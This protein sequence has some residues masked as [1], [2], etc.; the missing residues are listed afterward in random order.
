MKKINFNTKPANV[1]KEANYQVISCNPR[2]MKIYSVLFPGNLIK[3]HNTS[4]CVQGRVVHIW[5]HKA[6]HTET[7]M[8]SILSFKWVKRNIARFTIIFIVHNQCISH[9]C[10][11]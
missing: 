10:L 6:V 2:Q 7:Q 1:S 9:P 3:A 11:I 5:S 4:A 8:F